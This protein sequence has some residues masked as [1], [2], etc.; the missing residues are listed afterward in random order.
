MSGGINQELLRDCKK[1]IK[2]EDIVK[3]M[4][5]LVGVW[6]EEPTYESMAEEIYYDYVSNNTN[7]KAYF[8]P[9]MNLRA[10]IELR[11]TAMLKYSNT[12]IY[13]GYEGLTDAKDIK[14]TRIKFLQSVL[15]DE[16]VDKDYQYFIISNF[17]VSADRTECGYDFCWEWALADGDEEKNGYRG[18]ISYIRE[19]LYNMF[20]P[21]LKPY[22]SDALDRVLHEMRMNGGKI[23][24]SKVDVVSK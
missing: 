9:G 5:K 12:E 21:S 19:A 2:I 16:Y 4:K 20:P 10:F 24:G 3:D 14:A 15:N 1:K 13:N 7:Y 18:S 23:F 17:L 22:A 8:Q 6:D 11:K